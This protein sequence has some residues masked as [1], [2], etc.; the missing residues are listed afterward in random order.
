MT[1][2]ISHCSEDKA[3][4]DELIRLLENTATSSA[5]EIRCSSDDSGEKGI[6]GGEE[7]FKWIV[8][9]INSCSVAL[10]VLTKRSISRPWV[11]WEFGATSIAGGY[12]SLAATA[13][14]EHQDSNGGKKPCVIPVLIGAD[15]SALKG[16]PYSPL[17]AIDGTIRAGVRKLIRQISPPETIQTPSVNESKEI[18]L[19]I[20]TYLERL[21]SHLHALER[22]LEEDAVR[23]WVSTA[24]NWFAD[25][26]ALLGSALRQL[27]QSPCNEALS[28]MVRDLR[29]LSQETILSLDRYLKINSHHE[30]PIPVEYGRAQALRDA[31]E[32]LVREALK[33]SN[34][35]ETINEALGVSC[36]GAYVYAIGRLSGDGKVKRNLAS[37]LSV[38]GHPLPALISLI[39]GGERRKEWIEQNI[40]NSMGEED[41]AFG[42]LLISQWPTIPFAIVLE[43]KQRGAWS[44]SRHWSKP[45]GKETHPLL[46]SVS[47]SGDVE[48]M[49]DALNHAFEGGATQQLLEDFELLREALAGEPNKLE[50]SEESETNKPLEQYM[51]TKIKGGLLLPIFGQPKIT[52]LILT[53][54]PIDLTGDHSADVSGA[55]HRTRLS[56]DALFSIRLAGEQLQG[57]I[58]SHAEAQGFRMPPARRKAPN[59]RQS[60]G[61]TGRTKA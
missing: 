24:S 29:L 21:A 28:T 8:N 50:G 26:N 3:I 52:L 60:N 57:L 31:F 59:S 55:G 17:E 4:V 53:K 49:E 1:I 48:G 14:H 33:S 10:V 34:F 36:F 45:N 54:N 35:F 47:A 9:E 37:C 18:E 38:P 15:P 27:L 61:A 11:L 23:Q 12:K 40:E 32:E 6:P 30:L 5:N 58:A 16:G 2:F 51:A 25:N 20:G 44:A 41:G 42:H 22:C 13:N 56:P 46:Y 39:G 43:F 19:A 7:W